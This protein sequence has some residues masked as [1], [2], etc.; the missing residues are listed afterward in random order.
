MSSLI[1][2]ISSPHAVVL[3]QAISTASMRHKVIAD[4]IANVNTPGFKRSEV[5][6]EDVLRESMETKSHISMTATH[7]RHISPLSRSTPVMPQVHTINENSV[8]NDGN[9]VDIEIEMA[10]MAKNTVYYDATI[11]QLNRYFTSIKSAINE[12]RR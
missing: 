5:R 10:N 11:Q 7:P 6:F 8:R 1:S 9:N 12:G 2:S 4:N 3:E